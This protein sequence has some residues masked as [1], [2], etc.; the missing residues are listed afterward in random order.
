MLSCN[1]FN[2]LLEG[3]RNYETYVATESEIKNKKFIMKEIFFLIKL[4]LFP[5]KFECTKN[6]QNVYNSWKIYIVISKLKSMHAT[7][8]ILA[9]VFENFIFYFLLYFVLNF[10][11]VLEK[12]FVLSIRIYTVLCMWIRKLVI[13]IVECYNQRDKLDQRNWFVGWPR[14]IL[15]FFVSR[16]WRCLLNTFIEK[17]Q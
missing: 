6:I 2:P 13:F 7:V 4:N 1:F 12:D 17:T 3:C 9:L 16:Y 15:L 10:F 5:Y 8:Y 14:A 11:P